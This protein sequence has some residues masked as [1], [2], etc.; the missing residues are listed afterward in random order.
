MRAVA[1]QELR[2]TRAA[3]S[4]GSAGRLHP[5]RR[6]R[7]HDPGRP[8]D[9]RQRYYRT[10][11][12]LV[13]GLLGLGM[14]GLGLALLAAGILRET[15]AVLVGETAAGSVSVGSKGG[16]QTHE[17]RFACCS[18]SCSAPACR[19]RQANWPCRA[20]P[21]RSASTATATASPSSTPTTRA[22]ARSPSGFC[23]GQDRAFQLEILLRVAPRHAV[24]A[25]RPRRLARRSPVARGSASTAPRSNS[26]PS[27]TR[28][29][30][31]RSRPTRAA[32]RPGRAWAVRGVPHEFALLGSRPTPWTPADTLAV[33]KLLSFSL[34]SN[35]DAETRPAQG[36]APPTAPRP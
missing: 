24:R 33:T 14:V 27:S 16:L 26:S 20:S 17:S 10:F 15:I 22:T 30:A 32:S 9:G 31:S 5:A 12:L 7:P 23:H 35:W 34:T 2:S 18:D 4:S 21:A 8:G 29:S 3:S 6:G 36:S 1:R 11:R 25:R 19:P 13:T 28:T